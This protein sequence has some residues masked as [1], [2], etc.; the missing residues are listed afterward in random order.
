MMGLFS[1]KQKVRPRA[2][3]YEP[4]YYDPTRDESLKRRMRIRSRVRRR[5][6]SHAL[7]YLAA[8]LFFAFYIYNALGG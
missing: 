7:L 6:S 1:L 4:R 2:F 5:R 3:S 8:L